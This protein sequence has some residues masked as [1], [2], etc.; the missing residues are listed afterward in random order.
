MST[1]VLSEDIVGV[2]SKLNDL[3][4]RKNELQERIQLFENKLIM[5]REASLALATEEED[6]V[7]QLQASGFSYDQAPIQK[8]PTTILRDTPTNDLPPDQLTALLSSLLQQKAPTSNQPLPSTPIVP[9]SASSGFGNIYNFPQPAGNTPPLPP[10]PPSGLGSVM[11]PGGAQPRIRAAPKT[12]TSSTP[13]L[14]IRR[15]AK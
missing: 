9:T 5:T 11:T 2:V 7:S 6:L 8:I 12:P 1:T 13:G 14:S 4:S 3:Q 15:N 10:V